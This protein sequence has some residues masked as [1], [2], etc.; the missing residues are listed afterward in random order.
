[1]KFNPWILLSL[2]NWRTNI[3]LKFLLVRQDSFDRR[4]DAK[5]MLSKESKETVRASSSMITK[6][7]RP[8]NVW[9][10]R[11]QSLLESLKYSV[12]L[13]EYKSTLQGVRPRLHLLNL[14]Y[15]HF[16]IFFTVMW[17]TMGKNTFTS[18][19]SLSQL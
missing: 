2:I 4:P 15:D 14:H 17:M 12:K 1:M 9:V 10:D 11:G 16:K 3:G 19:R 13:K 6:T 8:K 18:Y 7:N 5:G